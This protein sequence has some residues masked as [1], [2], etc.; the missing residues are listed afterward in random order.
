MRKILLLPAVGLAAV[1]VFLAAGGSFGSG[2]VA[3]DSVIV[4]GEKRFSTQLDDMTLNAKSYEGKTV[5]LEG[6]TA[7]LREGFRWRF[8]V[9]RMYSCCGWDGY[10]VGLPCEYGGGTPE[11]D[12]WVEVEGTLRVDDKNLPY[13]EVVKLTVKETPGNRV[14]YS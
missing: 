2:T 13:L 5:R 14:V 8:A 6:F 10:P 1:V 3:G 9:V 11:E 12:D 4:I 7:R